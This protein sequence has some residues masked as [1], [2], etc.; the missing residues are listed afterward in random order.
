VDCFGKSLTCL[1]FPAAILAAGGLTLL[2]VCGP[3]AATTFHGRLPFGVMA[4]LSKLLKCPIADDGRAAKLF[5]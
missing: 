1:T 5:G 2:N 3:E 4:R